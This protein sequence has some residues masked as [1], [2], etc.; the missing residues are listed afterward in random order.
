MVE[1]STD[2]RNRTAPELPAQ[3]R[4]IRSSTAF[5]RSGRRRNNP[6]SAGASCSFSSARQAGW[7][8]SP[9]PTTPMPFLRAQM[10]RCC[11]S[12]FLL[13]ARENREWTCRSA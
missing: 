4:G 6:G 9:V 2:N 5:S 1:I 3:A 8:K 13:V 10:D 11:R 7:V 12:Q